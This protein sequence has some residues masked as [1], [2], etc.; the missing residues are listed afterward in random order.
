MVCTDENGHISEVSCL[1]FGHKFPIIIS[2]LPSR[3]LCLTGVAPE[4]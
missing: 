4:R 1:V 3:R 2:S